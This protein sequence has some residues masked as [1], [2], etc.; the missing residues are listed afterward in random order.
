MEIHVKPDVVVTRS[1]TAGELREIAGALCVKL[2][3]GE[4]VVT[5]SPEPPVDKS[6]PWQPTND[7]GQPI[8]Q[9]KYYKG[10]TWS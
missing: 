1:F 7:Y 6:N 10:G 9:L 4:R 3:P 5:F 2:G 8:G